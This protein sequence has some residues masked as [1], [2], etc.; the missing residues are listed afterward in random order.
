M[1]LRASGPV[2]DDQLLLEETSTPEQRRRKRRSWRTFLGTGQEVQAPVLQVAVLQSDPEAGDAQRVHVQV[3]AVLV[4]GDFAADE[5]LLEDVHALADDRLLEVERLV[6]ALHVVGERDA[7]ELV[8]ERVQGVA[9]LV[10]HVLLQDGLV[11]VPVQD[12]LLVGLLGVRQILH[13]LLLQEGPNL[14]RARQKVR[15][16]QLERTRTPWTS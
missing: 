2:Q 13:R 10:E 3:A 1:N 7:L 12:V 8:V 6:D 9:D 4:D 14:V 11:A 15:V 16:R 5:R